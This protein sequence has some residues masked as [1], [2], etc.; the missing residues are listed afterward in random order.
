VTRYL[1]RQDA[2]GLPGYDYWLFDSCKLVRMHFDGDE[3][4][5]GGELIEDPAVI[6]QH[7][8]W[9]DAAWHRALGRDDF[10]RQTEPSASRAS[11]RLA[12]RS[13]R[14]SVSSALSRG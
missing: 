3:N 5:L 7:N 6:V 9:R 14:G 8:Y 4:F 1:V 2:T 11:M 10:C 13:A 12:I